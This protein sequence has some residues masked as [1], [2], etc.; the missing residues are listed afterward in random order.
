MAHPSVRIGLV[1]E[2]SLAFYRQILRGINRF[3]SERPNWL[4]TPIACNVRAVRLV[5]SL[6]CRGYIAHIFHPALAD[7]L[8]AFRRPIINVSGVLPQ[9]P[10]P[11]V[12]A[13]HAE[14]G[15]QA[16]RH[17]LECGLRQLGFVGYQRH[18]F[19]TERERGFREVAKIAGV[20]VATFHEP[21]RRCEDPSGVWRWNEP[22]LTWLRKLPKPV[23]VLASH[24][25]QGAQIAEY[26][27][28]L[29]LTVPDQVAIV[30]VD[31][32][33]LLC[34]LSR[35]SLSSVR[36]PA[37]RIGYE[38][39]RLL[40]QWLGG[41]R[42][43]ERALVLPPAG[44]M[45]RQSSNLQAVPDA[46]VAAAVRFIHD[47]AHEPLHVSDVLR[48]VPMAR[49]ALER[50]FRRWLQRSILEEIRRAHVIVAQ[51]L[52]IAT[53]LPMSQIAIRCGLQS[54][55]HLSIAFRQVTKVTPTAFRRQSRL[56]P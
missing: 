41:S 14:V 26:C 6:Q 37:E 18:H 38:A 55:R 28:Q 11:R 48:E 46:G 1:L 44:V 31:D 22:L 35:P 39:A 52:L 49:R 15:R 36:L 54:S 13:D 53:D 40:D 19:A 8:Q 27:H 30:G 43:A 24:D 20:P 29:D 5:R 23:G 51:R 7:A 3:A 2:H 17:L 10:F 16:A 21:G 45:V 33:D 25:T 32:D 56:K 12:V 47:H 50:R 9:L 42:P 34:D 4:L